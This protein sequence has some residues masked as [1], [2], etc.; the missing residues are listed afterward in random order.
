[1]VR[2]RAERARARAFIFFGGLGFWSWLCQVCLEYEMES[3]FGG[4]FGM[5]VGG[6][7]GTS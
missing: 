6:H 3:W 4:W 1:M 7:L 5:Y 2:E